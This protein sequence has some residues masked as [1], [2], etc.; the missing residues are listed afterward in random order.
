MIELTILPHQNDFLTA[1]KKAFDG[2]AIKKSNDVYAN[3]IIDLQD[4]KINN[5]INELWNGYE[6][7]P[8]IPQ[9]WR[10]SDGDDYLG[11]DIKMET[12]TGKTYCYTRM[13]Y[14]LNQL[15]GFHKFIILVPTTAIREGSKSFLTADYAKRHFA[16]LYPKLQIDRAVEK[17]FDFLASFHADTFQH[18]SALADNNPFMR[19][20]FHIDRRLKI[21]HVLIV[22]GAHA[23]NGNGD[24]VRY[25]FV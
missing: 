3:P 13:M 10:K 20:P 15:Y 25:F 23:V 9:A 7:L 8:S 5:N 4:E 24:A 6:E 16:D 17:R 14:E 11:L 22:I 21:Q 1:I 18:L 2:V 19:I 12:G